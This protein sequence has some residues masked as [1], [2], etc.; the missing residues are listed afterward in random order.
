MNRITKDSEIPEIAA[1][2]SEALEGAGIN[3]VLSGGAA[4]TVYADN[5]YITGDLDFVSSA[6]TTQIE[7]ILAD[8]GFTR[9]NRRYFV[10]KETTFVVEFPTGP[11][12]VGG[13][14]VR[15]SA[16]IKTPVGRIRIITPTHCV[17]DRLAHFYHWNDPQALEQAVAVA[18]SQNVDIDVIRDWSER[19]GHGA[20]YKRFRDLLKKS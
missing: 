17:V 10:H 20:K 1:F 2:V 7:E 18:K 9:R 5:P 19:E 4:V 13:E 16:Q 15:E 12:A 6:P 14:I 8:L 3:A 11:V